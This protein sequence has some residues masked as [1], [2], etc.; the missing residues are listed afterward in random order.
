M[1]DEQ[2]NITQGLVKDFVEHLCTASALNSE[3][4]PTGHCPLASG[5]TQWR[6]QYEGDT[7]M[8]RGDLNELETVQ[9]W[10]DFWEYFAC[11]T[12]QTKALQS[13]HVFR[14]GI[15]PLYTD[16]KNKHGE[17]FELRAR[18][19]ATAETMWTYLATKLV[20]EKIPRS[21]PL[22]ILITTA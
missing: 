8:T 2:K 14:R 15:L 1:D 7:S 10:E 6:Q 5:W 18:D 9:S 19:H 17:V 22:S 11:N 20:M 12:S 3:N 16:E 13:M 4:V 21:F